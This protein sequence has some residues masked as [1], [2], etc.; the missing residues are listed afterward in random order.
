MVDKMGKGKNSE[1]GEWNR[2][3]VP[4]FFLSGPFSSSLVGWRYSFGLR[5]IL[6]YV[7]SFF[8]GALTLLVPVR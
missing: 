4:I 1:G 8:T 3:S 5:R 2:G 6:Q 7:V